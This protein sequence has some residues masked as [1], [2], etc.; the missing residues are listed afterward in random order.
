MH[1]YIL[2]SPS[3]LLKQSK[4]VHLNFYTVGRCAFPFD[5]SLIESESFHADTQKYIQDL[6]PRLA[7]TE[8][9]INE[10]TRESQ[11]KNK[12]IHD[13]YS[14]TPKFKVGDKVYFKNCARKVGQN[15]KLVRPYIGPYFIEQAG[16]KNFWFKLRHCETDELMKNPVFADRL[17]TYKEGED[18]FYTKTMEAKQRTEK[19][20]AEKK[21]KQTDK[22]PGNSAAA[23]NNNSQEPRTSRFRGPAVQPDPPKDQNPGKGS[24]SNEE[25]YPVKQVIR[26]RGKGP[27][28][29]FLV[30]FDDPEKTLQWVKSKDLSH[31]C[32]EIF[33]REQASKRRP[34]KR[35]RS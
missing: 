24:D 33:H 11:I 31:L 14:E 16:H 35:T 21:K 23:D 28:T 10:N 29:R 6:I 18:K 12:T 17:K 20:E 8:R 22:L 19:R 7:L 32:K 34:K 25:W 13:R 30:M 2:I 5:V 9:V 1:C 4:R 27:Q 3:Q 26:R 15:N